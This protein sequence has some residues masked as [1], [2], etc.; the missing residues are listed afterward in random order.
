MSSIF[1]TTCRAAL[2]AA[3]VSL[4]PSLLCAQAEVRVMAH[5]G[6]MPFLSIHGGGQVQVTPRAARSTLY[7]EYNQWG[8]G[9]ACESVVE[10]GGVPFDPVD[11]PRCGETGYTVH[12]GVI[13][14]LKDA[15]VAWRPYVS[16]GAGLARVLNR[17]EEHRPVR[18]SL[19]VEAGYD[20]GGAGPLNL[21][22]GA[23]WQGRPQVGTD[24]AGPVI[25]FRLRLNNHR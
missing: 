20:V 24:Y 10:D 5:G 9:M 15:G 17:H 19:A 25:G 7:A 3:G 18:A 22:L 13:R 1:R 14:H 16:A 23:R 8:W 2:L 6:L 11:E 12:A 21:R 4:A